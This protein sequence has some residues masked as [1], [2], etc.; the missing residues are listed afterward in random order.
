MLFPAVATVLAAA[1]ARGACIPVQPVLAVERAGNVPLRQPSDFVLAGER[2]FV[3]D[4]LNERVAILDLQ[5][6]TLGVVPLPGPKGGS[7][8]GIGFGGADRLFLA[9]ADRAE[10]VVV[11]LDGKPVRTFPVADAGEASRPAGILVSRA[12]CFV[13]DGAAGKVRSFTLGGEPVVAWGG[14]GEGPAQFRFPFRVAQDN[15]D[16]VI[17]T[18]SLNAR[19][20]VFT[21][22]GDHLLTFGEF[23]TT[24][25]RLFRP[26]GLAVLEGDRILVADN[27]FGSIQLF[28]PDGGYQGVLCEA[29]GKPV[30]AQGPVSLAASGRLVYVLE[31]GAGRLSAYRIER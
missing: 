17:V 31:T 26:A 7:W 27:Y 5:G 8:L 12:S 28:G 2:L 25:G 23:G 22:R 21:P 30:A 1:P 13:A 3:L 15:R 6:R 19:V 14:S 18:D 29:A 24:E 10:V 16:R 4:D 11:D 9:A 20:Q